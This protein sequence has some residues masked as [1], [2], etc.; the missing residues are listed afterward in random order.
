MGSAVSIFGKLVITPNRKQI[1]EIHASEIKEIN[2]GELNNNFPLQKQNL[3]LI[4]LRKHLDIRAKTK[5]F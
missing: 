4:F 2:Q 3:S 5:T 1:C